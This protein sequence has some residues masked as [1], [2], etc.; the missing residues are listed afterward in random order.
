M[1]RAKTKETLVN[2]ADKSRRLDLLEAAFVVRYND[3]FHRISDK[4]KDEVGAL[5]SKRISFELEE[6]LKRDIKKKS[7]E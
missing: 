2:F 6:W 4:V 7:I 1:L 5:D 3:E